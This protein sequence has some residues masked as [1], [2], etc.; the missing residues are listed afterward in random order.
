RLSGGAYRPGRVQPWVE[1]ATAPRRL[2]VTLHEHPDATA[3]IVAWS[4][5]SRTGLWNDLRFPEDVAYEDQIIAQRLFTRARAFDVIPD[6]AV[7][8][9]LRADGTSITQ[10]KHQL[11][12]LTDYLAAL[13][14]GID[15]LTA[16]GMSE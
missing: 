6:I 8:W 15:V 5:L 2:G 10:G 3:N 12:V 14:G 4:K 13:R 7:H 9:R 16:A 1:R 11:A